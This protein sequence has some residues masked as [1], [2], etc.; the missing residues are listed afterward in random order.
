MPISPGLHPKATT[1]RLIGYARVS[2]NDQRLDLQI[3]ALK[4]AGCSKIFAD[5]GMSGAKASRPEL[6][7]AMNQLRHGDTLVVYK[8]DRLGRSVLNLADIITRFDPE[9]IHFCSL[10]EGIDT[11]TPGGK[12]VFHVFA[13]VAE[14]GRDLI[15]ENTME[16]L[17]AARQ[18]GARIGRP[19][20]LTK[21]DLVE[22]ERLIHAEGLSHRQ[23]ADQ[24]QVSESTVQRG[25]RQHL[26]DASA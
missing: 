20:S 12:L 14:F 13:A 6:D 11:T 5:Q 25:L 8:L 7:G 24:F 26:A 17:K 2:T 9:G 4:S 23:V 19:P 15:R 3:S 16:G 10:T 1:G 18:R 21:A 22:I